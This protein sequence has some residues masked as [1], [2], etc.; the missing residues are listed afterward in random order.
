MMICGSMTVNS[1]TLNQTRLTKQMRP[2]GHLGYATWIETFRRLICG[3]Q[4]AC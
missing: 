3:L 2:C 1:R 4:S